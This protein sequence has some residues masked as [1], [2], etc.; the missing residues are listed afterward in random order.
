M[1]VFAED[2]VFTVGIGEEFVDKWNLACKSSGTV[3][4]MRN[5]N[6]A[7][8]YNLGSGYHI[9]IDLNGYSISGVG[10]DADYLFRIYGGA[11]LTVTDSTKT[12]AGKIGVTVSGKEYDEVFLIEETGTLTLYAGTLKGNSDEDCRLVVVDYGTFNL[13]GGAVDG[14]TY[15]GDGAGVYINEG[16]LNMTGGSICNNRGDLDNDYGGG[17]YF[18]G[19]DDSRLNITGGSITNNSAYR[20]GGIYLDDGYAYLAGGSICDNYAEH[21]S[22][23]YYDAV[24]MDGLELSGDLFVV[25]NSVPAPVATT[26]ANAAVGTDVNSVR[27]EVFLGGSLKIYGNAHGNLYLPEVYHITVRNDIDTTPENHAWISLTNYFRPIETGYLNNQINTNGKDYSV[28]FCQDAQMAYPVE[29]FTFS[30]DGDPVKLGV[31]DEP[32][33]L[34]TMELDQSAIKDGDGNTL[35]K[36]TDYKLTVN[37]GLCQFFIESDKYIS[38]ENAANFLRC[39]RTN[40]AC[41][42]TLVKEESSC[43]GEKEVRTYYYL[44]K[45][46]LT[47]DP[48]ME[49]PYAITRNVYFTVSVTC[50]HDASGEWCMDETS[51]WKECP[52]GVKTEEAAHTYENGSCTV[53]GASDPARPPFA[54][55]TFRLALSGD[56]CMRFT[57]TVN[58]YEAV[59]DGYMRFEIGG[60]SVQ[61]VPLSELTPESDGTYIFPCNINALQMADTITVSFCCGDTV[62]G[63]HTT[64]VRQYI[65]NMLSKYPDDAELTALVKAI[66]DYGHYAQLALQEAHGFDLGTDGRYQAMK[67]YSEIVLPDAADLAEYKAIKSGSIPQITD[68]TRTLALD[69]RTD[70]LLDFTCEEGYVPDILVV[71]SG[72]NIIDCE[73]TPLQS[74]WRLTIPDIPA[75]RLGD[76]YTVTVDGYQMVIQINALSYA[77]SILDNPESSPSLKNAVAA[78]WQYYHAAMAY[79]AAQQ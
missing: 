59:K 78:L 12:A 40:A 1:T 39:I 35:K 3:K 37:R 61:E 14:N 63:P 32:G 18:D 51:H 34:T 41:K 45:N 58:D 6:I 73:L 76:F 53:C 4:L 36:D 71:G 19:S 33:D 29:P 25:G 8:E 15:N 69:H 65:A 57:G 46:T 49:G 72:G 28:C 75:H 13:Y 77:Y 9:T 74:G 50:A 68:L 62:V 67:G 27:C 21:F 42:T 70:I 20:G 30:D 52:C 2:N 56:L 7:N 44:C 23:I 79:R 66:A 31:S 16:T 11:L 26:D 24:T 17:I 10:T 64:S 55:G 22:A 43:S 60:T 54:F 48:F 47:A 38:G 5:V